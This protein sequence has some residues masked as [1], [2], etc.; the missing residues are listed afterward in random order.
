MKGSTVT[1]CF[2]LSVNSAFGWASENPLSTPCQTE[3][4]VIDEQFFKIG[5][6]SDVK[7]SYS[8]APNWLPETAKLFLT[9]AQSL[10]LNADHNQIMEAVTVPLQLKSSSSGREEYNWTDNKN[11][12]FQITKWKGCLSGIYTFVMDHPNTN[13]GQITYLRHRNKIIQNPGKYLVKPKPGTCSHKKFNSEMLYTV[14]GKNSKTYRSSY[15]ASV[16][17]SFGVLDAFNFKRAIVL[18]KLGTP[19]GNGNDLIWNIHHLGQP[20]VNLALSV[21]NNCDVS[22]TA[23]WISKN[24]DRNKL[25]FK[26]NYFEKL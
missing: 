26:R 15:P 14:N 1:T 18:E 25:V 6:R 23:T 11:Y 13:N 4:Y 21:E 22:R 12:R 19:E 10:P 8:G 20:K 2:L 9:E 3:S 24:G 17:N 5:F 16:I 7:H